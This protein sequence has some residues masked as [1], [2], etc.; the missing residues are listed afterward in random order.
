[1]LLRGRGWNHFSQQIRPEPQNKVVK[2]SSGAEVLD[3]DPNSFWTK[4][5]EQD[6]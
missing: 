1:V 4:K 3:M 6:G 2:A 5:R